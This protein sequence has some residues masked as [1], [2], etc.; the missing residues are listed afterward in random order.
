MLYLKYK[1]LVRIKRKDID[2]H[3]EEKE[4]KHLGLKLTAMEDLINKQSEEIS[5]QSEKINKQNEEF[6]K[7]SEE[8]NKLNENIKTQNKVISNTSKQIELLYFITDTT[9][10]IWEIEDVKYSL[11]YSSISKQYEVPGYRFAFKV[12]HY[13]SFSIVFPRTMIKPDRPFIAKC[14]IVLHSCHTI[15]CGMIEVKQKD[16]TRGYERIITYI[17]QEDVDKYSEPQ[18]PRCCKKRFNSRNIYNFAIV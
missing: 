1:C 6:T 5:K 11:N 17:S 9:K 13:G 15:N 12:Q 16:V 14:H 18:F 7:Q 8:I 10:I 3:L 2:T 4:T